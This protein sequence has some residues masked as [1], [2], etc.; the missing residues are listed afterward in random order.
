MPG[1][2]KSLSLEQIRDGVAQLEVRRVLV[3][4]WLTPTRPDRSE[5]VNHP[6][7]Q[8]NIRIDS[9]HGAQ[10]RATQNN[11]SSASERTAAVEYVLAWATLLLLDGYYSSRR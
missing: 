5:I 4:L 11:G 3:A 7:Q 6:A 1:Y 8:L 9:F 10:L 2:A